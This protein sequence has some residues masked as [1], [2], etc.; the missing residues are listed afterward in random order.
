MLEEERVRRSGCL[1]KRGRRGG[2]K[3]ERVEEADIRRGVW[4]RGE[5][6]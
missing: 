4:E 6:V 3:E 2:Y 5:K 1:G